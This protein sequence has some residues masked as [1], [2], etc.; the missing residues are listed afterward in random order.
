MGRWHVVT[1]YL[2]THSLVC[3]N[4]FVILY[5]EIA[6][7]LNLSLEHVLHQFT[8]CVKFIHS[9]RYTHRVWSIRIFGCAL[10]ALSSPVFLMI[11]QPSSSHRSTFDLHRNCLHPIKVW[12]SFSITTKRGWIQHKASI[13]WLLNFWHQFSM[14]MQGKMVFEHEIRVI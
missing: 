8:E 9:E 3:D 13:I 7:I 4:F 2:V 12:L 11:L 1:F 6:N 14:N 5:Y 10:I